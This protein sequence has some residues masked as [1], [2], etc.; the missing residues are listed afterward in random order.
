MPSL[1]YLGNVIDNE[2]RISEC[3][4]DSMQ[5]GNIAYIAN[6]YMLKRKIIK[7]AVKMQIYRTL[8][9]LVPYKS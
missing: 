7:R 9:K 8:I 1:K 3:V 2:G 5:A 4:K 6:Y